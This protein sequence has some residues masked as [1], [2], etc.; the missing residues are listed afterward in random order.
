MA[1]PPGNPRFGAGTRVRRVL[2]KGGWDLLE[3]DCP[4]G[5]AGECLDSVPEPLR[6]VLGTGTVASKGCPLDLY[7]SREGPQR[8]RTRASGTSIGCAVDGGG[9]ILTPKVRISGRHGSARRSFEGG[10]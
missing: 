3:L 1:F 4:P 8:F 7:P 10:R 6:R 2:S 5:F 9:G